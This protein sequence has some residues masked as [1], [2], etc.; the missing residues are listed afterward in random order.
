MPK[1]MTHFT[2]GRLLIFLSLISVE[3]TGQAIKGKI[4]WTDKTFADTNVYITATRI[5]DIKDST[6]VT[7]TNRNLEFLLT[8]KEKGEY[9]VRLKHVAYNDTSFIVNMRGD[10]STILTI[11]YPNKICQYD[12][13]RNIKICPITTHRDK[14]IPISYGLPTRRIFRIAKRNRVY[15]GGCVI[16]D[17]DP[18]WYCE[19]HELTF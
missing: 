13:A 2:F 5:R 19:R 12:L 10:S 15:L 6:F 18:T 7:K 17:C 16:T 9:Y 14:I 8:L 4:N 1:T 11:N 3:L